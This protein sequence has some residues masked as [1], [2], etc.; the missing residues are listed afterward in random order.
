MRSA[1]TLIR[2]RAF[3]S[4]VDLSLHWAHRSFCSVRRVSAQISV[5]LVYICCVSLCYYLSEVK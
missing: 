5:F 1:K 3:G 2:L 4:H